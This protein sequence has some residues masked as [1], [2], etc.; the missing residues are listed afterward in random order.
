[1]RGTQP[2][3]PGPRLSPGPSNDPIGTLL[4]AYDRM[5]TGLGH[6]TFTAGRWLHKWQRLTWTATHQAMGH[7]LDGCAN[8]AL[9]RT[10]LQALAALHKT[11][12]SLLVHSAQ[13]LA[14]GAKLWRGQ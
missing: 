3:A 5:G 1:M 12:A 4:A 13:I 6:S 2:P 10:P 11:H 14:N 7:Y 8:V 9:A